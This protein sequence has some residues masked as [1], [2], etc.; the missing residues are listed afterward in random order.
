MAT[1]RPSVSG[2]NTQEG[3]MRQGMVRRNNI[4]AAPPRE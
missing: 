3:H 4:V 1:W 2:G